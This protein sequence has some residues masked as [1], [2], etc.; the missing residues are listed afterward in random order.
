MTIQTISST[1]KPIARVVGTGYMPIV[2]YP[3]RR[4]EW[5]RAERFPRK[6]KATADEALEYATR[7]IWYRQMRELTSMRRL[8]AIVRP[9]RVVS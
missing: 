2:Y 3:E 8:Q 1:A 4:E 6:V 7:T 5:M 9:E